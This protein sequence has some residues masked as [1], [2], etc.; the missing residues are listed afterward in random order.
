M[1]AKW[2]RWLFWTLALGA[3]FY[4]VS[5]QRNSLVN[6][7]QKTASTPVE[8]TRAESTKQTPRPAARPSQTSAA[9]T[10][11]L[12]VRLNAP[13][14]TVT[15][16][17]DTLHQLIGQYFSNMQNRQGRPIGDS[18]DLARVLTGSNPLH[19]TVIA[20]DHPAIGP[21]GHLLDRWGTPYHLHQLSSRSIDVRSA[22][23]DRQLYTADDVVNERATQSAAT[24]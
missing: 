22:G 4:F 23:P 12:A 19:L 1:V 20:A 18:R 7:A 3:L 9:R 16:D 21:Q 11:P 13:D 2:Q 6:G 14:G 10:S 5:S 15:E 17:V 8:R 24:P